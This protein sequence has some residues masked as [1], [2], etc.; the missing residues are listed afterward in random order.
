MSVSR[1]GGA[2]QLPNMRRRAGKLKLEYSQFLELEVFTR[3]GALTDERT[4][5][6]IERGRRIRAV[7]AQP[8]LT[9]LALSHQVALLI[10]VDEGR[11]DSLELEQVAPFRAR[12]GAALTTVCPRIVARIEPTGGVL[13]DEEHQDLL[14]VIDT[15]IA[16]FAAG[17]P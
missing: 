8:Q 6:T 4:R 2:T 16:A 10:A 17:E 14:R 7:L 11:L 12:L 5:K 13:S 9:P 15:V 1:V 3:F